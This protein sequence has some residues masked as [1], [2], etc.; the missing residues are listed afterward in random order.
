MDKLQYSYEGCCCGCVSAADD[1][2]PQQDRAANGIPAQAVTPYAERPALPGTLLS[3]P[4]GQVA[5]Y[6]LP[7]Y[8]AESALFQTRS[9]PRWAIAECCLTLPLLSPLLV[10]QGQPARPL[11]LPPV[12]HRPPQP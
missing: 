12:R 6:K 10:Q 2:A 4:W 9:C 11:A 8:A 7:L 5:L 1:A 3:C